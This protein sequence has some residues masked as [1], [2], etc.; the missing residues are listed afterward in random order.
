MKH[1]RISGLAAFLGALSV[2]T[3]VHAQL[4]N[5]TY[6]A[7]EL[8]HPVSKFDANNMPMGPSGSNTVL[9]IRGKMIVMGSNDSGKPPGVFHVFDVTDP[10]N[11]KRLTSYMSASTQTLRE[12]HGMP[13]AII[14]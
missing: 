12:L 13:L 14:D 6:T 11:P 4:G 8:W 5:L 3:L 2:P 9:M 10:R 1:A 7:A